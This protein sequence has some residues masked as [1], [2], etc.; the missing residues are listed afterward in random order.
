MYELGPGTT[1]M[2]EAYQRFYA[3]AKEG[4]ITHG[5]PNYPTGDPVLAAHIEATAADM[6]ERG[7][8][9]RKLKSTQVIDACVATVMAFWRADRQ[10]APSKYEKEG[11]FLLDHGSQLEEP[12]EEDDEYAD[13]EYDDD[14]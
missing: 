10:E 11:L 1:A 3:A 8:R 14:D 12:L 9:I 2:V 5:G 6:T 4:T 13:D 7:W